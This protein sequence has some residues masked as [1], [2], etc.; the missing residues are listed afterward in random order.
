[1]RPLGEMGYI[2][3]FRKKFMMIWEVGLQCIVYVFGGIDFCTIQY[4]FL[5][6][7]HMSAQFGYVIFPSIIQ[8][9]F[10]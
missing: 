8:T 5:K 3:K 7:L 10:F 2:V 4:T 1:M 6:C 9:M